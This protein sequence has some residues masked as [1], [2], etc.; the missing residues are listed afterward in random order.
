MSGE[1]DEPVAAPCREGSS[2]TNAPVDPVGFKL[3]QED[4]ELLEEIEGMGGVLVRERISQK[5]AD[6]TTGD[7][8]AFA[9][10]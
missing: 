8:A 1:G 5:E 10:A 6:G 3:T 4:R 2:P 9:E 7:E